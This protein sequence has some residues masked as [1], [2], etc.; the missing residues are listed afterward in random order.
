MDPTQ[1]PRLIAEIALAD[2]R[3]RREDPS[4]QSGQIDMWAGILAE[5]PYDYAIRASQEHYTRSQWPI[6]PS[7]IATRWNAEVRNRMER[8]TDPTPDVDPN[9]ELAYRRALRDG[10]TAVAQ[11]VAAPSNVKALTAGLDQGDVHAMR[12]QGDLIDFIKASMAEGRRNAD[13]RRALV[14]R[15]PEVAAKLTEWPLSYAFPEQW[16]GAMPPEQWG[17]HRNTAPERVAILAL[18]AEA[19]A[20]DAKDRRPTHA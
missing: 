6:Q 15:H 20:L 5:I 16:S 7:D 13:L 3:V 8:H 4:E 17:G 19:E 12:Q 14:L 1:I 18:V 10:R 2:R 9:N 11:G